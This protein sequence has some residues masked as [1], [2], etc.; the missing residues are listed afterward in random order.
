M[1]ISDKRAAVH[2]RQKAREKELEKQRKDD[3]KSAKRALKEEKRAKK[4]REKEAEVRAKE[5]RDN[6]KYEIL[7]IFPDARK[8]KT[9]FT[10]KF[11]TRV[12]WT[13]PDLQQIKSVIPGVVISLEVKEG[14]HVE[15]GSHIMTFEAMKMHNLVL[16]P[17]DGTIEKIYVKEGEKVPKGGLMLYIKADKEFEIIEE[18]TISSD[19]GLIV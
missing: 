11:A 4:E 10:K 3:E 18:D 5:T 7:Q 6:L 2:K 8:Y 16:A 9:T 19:L 12:K 1:K 14:D 17:F 15:Q 13:R